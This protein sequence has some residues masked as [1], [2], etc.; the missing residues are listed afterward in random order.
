MGVPVAGCAL[1]Y[2]FGCCVVTV[3]I[4]SEHVHDVFGCLKT[5]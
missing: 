5:G 2:G 4:L 3:G 1:G